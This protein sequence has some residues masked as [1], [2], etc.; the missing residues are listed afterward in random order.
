MKSWDTKK[1]MCYPPIIIGNCLS[2]CSL[3]RVSPRIAF[4]RVFSGSRTFLVSRVF[5]FVRNL[6]LYNR[7]FFISSQSFVVVGRVLSSRSLFFG[8]F[9]FL[10]AWFYFFASLLLSLSLF[11]FLSSLLLFLWVFSFFFVSFLCIFM[12][13]T[14][15]DG[16]SLCSNRVLP[17]F[18]AL[19]RFR[20]FSFSSLSKLFSFRVFL[21]FWVVGFSSSRSLLIFGSFFF[22]LTLGF[23]FFSL[24]VCLG[25]CLSRCS[26]RVS[27]RFDF[28]A[29][30]RFRPSLSI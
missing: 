1:Y 15:L 18:R 3:H 11:L 17:Q 5:S 19:F 24:I 4:S 21:S 14:K 12:N 9:I 6:C 13:L 25:N 26:H 22:S 8:S 23:S 2:V 30:F 27:A 20:A 16:S 28:R 10:E 29:F 7:S